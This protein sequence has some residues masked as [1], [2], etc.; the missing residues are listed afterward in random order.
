MPAVTHRRRGERDAAPD[1]Q[2][3]GLDPL[4]QAGA[5]AD[6]GVRILHGCSLGCV[7]AKCDAAMVLR[8]GCVACCGGVSGRRQRGWRCA[9]LPPALTPV[10]SLPGPRSRAGYP[11]W[12]ASAGSGVNH[13]DGA[14]GEPRPIR[15]AY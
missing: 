7:G 3:V 2:T 11:C 15:G 5:G 9:G 14:R 13:P 6:L 12:L 8:S 1:E 10:I 4:D